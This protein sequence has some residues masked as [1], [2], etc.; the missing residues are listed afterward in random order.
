LEPLARP[1]P[2]VLVP[3]DGKRRIG[4]RLQSVAHLPRLVQPLH[5]LEPAFDRG[6]GQP[7]E[8]LDELDALD[9]VERRT[10]EIIPPEELSER[11]RLFPG[12]PRGGGLVLAEPL[13]AEREDPHRAREQET[14]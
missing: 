12:A 8:A 14:N 6:P 13:P 9:A 5:D 2:R 10:R 1:A 11:E 3:P 7:V 4:G